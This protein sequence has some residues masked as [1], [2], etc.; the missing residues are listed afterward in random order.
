M[1]RHSKIRQAQLVAL[2]MLP[3]LVG[4]STM[5]TTADASDVTPFVVAVPQVKGPLA[6]DSSSF[7]YIADGFDVEPRSRSAT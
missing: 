7:P 1:F 6:S 4:A 3:A 5:P 2:A